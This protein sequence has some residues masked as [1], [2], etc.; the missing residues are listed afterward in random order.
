MTQLNQDQSKSLAYELISPEVQLASQ[1]FK[2]VEAFLQATYRTQIGWH[3]ITDLTWIYRQVKHW[4][5]S[6]K[7]LD[8]GGGQGPLQFLLAEMGFNVTNID[9]ALTDYVPKPYRK[10][11]QLD[12]RQ[13]P[14]FVASEYLDLLQPKGNFKNKNIVKIW[15]KDWRHRKF[16]S[17]CN[18]WRVQTN[19]DQYPLGEIHWLKGNLCNIPELTQGSFGAVVSVSALEHIPDQLL[20]SAL[21]EIRRVVTPD[22]QWALTTSATE[23]AT[24]WFHEPSQGYCFSQSDLQARFRA[25]PRGFQDAS[26]ILNE[27]RSCKYLENNL[28][29]FYKT[30][31]KFGMPWGIWDP[32]YIPVG[33]VR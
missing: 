9:M 25:Q 19:H 24:S 8:A 28:A 2:E 1:D 27:Y 3:Y 15:I 21:Q 5:R 4:P 20:D 31:G 29:D 10:R 7:I 14:S 26:K 22:A 32:K 17:G 11:Y 30:S 23:Q 33:M 6:L 13:L 12:F 18:T 16:I